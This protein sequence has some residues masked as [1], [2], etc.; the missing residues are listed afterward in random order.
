[1]THDLQSN[2]QA[3]LIIARTY[4][5]CRLLRHIKG[6]GEHDVIEWT[7][8]ITTR[9]WLVGSIRG[10]GRGRADQKIIALGGCNAFVA[11]QHDFGERANRVN[12]AAA[13]RATEPLEDERQHLSLSILRKPL[14][15][16]PQT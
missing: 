9:G 10:D 7:C 12:R 16:S 13:L 15:L 3:L 8:R 5:R 6:R 1:M 14:D 2:R 4:R 11:H